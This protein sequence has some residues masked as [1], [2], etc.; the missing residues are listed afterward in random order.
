VV[1]VIWTDFGGVLTPPVSQTMAEYA[2]R[3]GV[4]PSLIRD[5]MAAVGDA[6]GTDVM[7][8]LD[9][10]LVTEDEWAALVEQAILR[11]HGVRVDLTR[12]G[13]KWFA[14]RPANRAWLDWL[15]ARRAEGYFVG[16]LSNMVPSWEQHWRRMVNP[17]GLFDALVLSYQV[18]CRKPEPEI[19]HLAAARADVDPACCLLVDDLEVNCVGAVSAGWQAV[20]FTTAADAAVAARAV[21]LPDKDHFR[22]APGQADGRRGAS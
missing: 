16:M 17:D 6:F 22:A 20:H 8:P 11:R 2:A 21:L 12:F 13:E 1:T 3:I 15:T 14:D 7:A 4:A 18:G 19:F 10:P 5:G 9:T